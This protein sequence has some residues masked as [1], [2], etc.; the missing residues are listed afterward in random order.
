MIGNRMG[1]TEQGTSLATALK[2][3]IF[4]LV[5]VALLAGCALV[6]PTGVYIGQKKVSQK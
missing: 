1:N 6:W 3:A 4:A 5:A 2:T